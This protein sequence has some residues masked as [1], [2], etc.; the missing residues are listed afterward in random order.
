MGARRIL[1]AN[2]LASYRQTLA[3]VLRELRPH[4]EVFETTSEDL[5]GEI[6]R[7]RPDL[8]ICSRVTFA[9]RQR[10]ANWVELYPEC[11]PYSTFYIDGQHRAKQDVQLSDLLELCASPP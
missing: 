10:V 1:V 2:E 4:V 6:S 3:I 9:L 7:L 8:V 11:K 5:E